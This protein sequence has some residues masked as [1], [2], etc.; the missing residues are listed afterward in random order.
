M[1]K[2]LGAAG[3]VIER[4]PFGAEEVEVTLR[5]TDV[6]SGGGVPGFLRVAFLW[7]LPLP[8]SVVAPLYDHDRTVS[9]PL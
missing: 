3:F 8:L 4:R 6:M 7:D 1:S 9:L 5:L 2:P